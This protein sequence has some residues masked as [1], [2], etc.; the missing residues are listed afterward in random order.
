MPPQGGSDFP[1]PTNTSSDRR[2][3]PEAMSSSRLL[4]GPNTIETA[5]E[6]SCATLIT[7]EGL[8]ASAATDPHRTARLT[9]QISLIRE[10]IA[11]LRR[12]HGDATN[13]LAYGFVL[14][15]VSG[16]K[17]RGPEADHTGALAG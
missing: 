2:L 14:G 8:R 3:D 4:L 1:S 12:G 10:G 6:A 11:D 9:Q 15:E 5:L 16:A 13:A 7:L 17:G